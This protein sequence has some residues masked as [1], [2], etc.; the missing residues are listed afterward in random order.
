[1]VE[2]KLLLA[3]SFNT[4][5]DCV[6]IYI[7]IHSACVYIHTYVHIDIGGMSICTYSWKIFHI[8]SLHLALCYRIG[9]QSNNYSEN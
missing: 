2:T 5:C 8:C 6:C 3:Y 1:M 9:T 7:Y 4:P